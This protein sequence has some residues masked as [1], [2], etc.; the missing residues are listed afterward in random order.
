[1]GDWTGEKGKSLVFAR[2]PKEERML[3]VG[4]VPFFFPIDAGTADPT[5]AIVFQPGLRTFG[6]SQRYKLVLALGIHPYLPN[7]QLSWAFL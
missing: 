3:A 7:P 5:R 1:M 2:S 6:A 4:T